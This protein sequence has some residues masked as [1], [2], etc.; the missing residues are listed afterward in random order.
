MPSITV[1]LPEAH[2][3]DFLR[4][5]LS[6]YASKSEAL[7]QTTESYLSSRGGISSL[8][9]DRDELADLTEL[10]DQLGWRL[11]SLPRAE[12]VTGDSYL[13]AELAHALLTDAASDVSERLSAAGRRPD[14]IV[15]TVGPAIRHVSSTFAFL[16]QTYAPPGS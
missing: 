14:R 11:D 1:Q 8:L 10:I 2:R 9:A 13:I 4:A 3:L 15:A 12:A 5:L 7:H 6:L 16:R